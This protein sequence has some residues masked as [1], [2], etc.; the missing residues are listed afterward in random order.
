MT[1]ATRKVFIETAKPVE[2]PNSNLRFFVIIAVISLCAPFAFMLL[3]TRPLSL[4]NQ[5]Q[6]QSGFT[7]TAEEFGSDWPFKVYKSAVVSCRTES[8]GS[9]DGFHVDRPFVTVQLG[10][11]AYGL[12]GAA[13][14]VGGY[15]DHR[16]LRNRDKWGY[17][18]IGAGVINDWIEQARS[19]CPRS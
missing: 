17:T 18:S 9:V 19:D 1:T 7:V 10:T 8:L 6:D 14:G 2:R 16:D 11:T 5:G 12:N 3:I 15:P 13:M 4:A